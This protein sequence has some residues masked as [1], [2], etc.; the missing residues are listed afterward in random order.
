M[1]FVRVFS[2]L[3]TSYR[4]RVVLKYLVLFSL[5]C[6]AKLINFCFTDQLFQITSVFE[7]GF[8][9]SFGKNCKKSLILKKL[10]LFC[11]KQAVDLLLE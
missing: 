3:I 7:H 2:R 6:P 11:R 5:I 9:A 4:A 1:L 8:Q 10:L